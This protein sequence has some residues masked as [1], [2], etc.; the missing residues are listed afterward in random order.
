MWLWPRIFVGPEVDVYHADEGRDAMRSDLVAQIN[1]DDLLHNYHALKAS[2]RPGVKLCAP[3]KADAYG[4]S[5]AIVA[6]VLY[7]AGVDMAAVATLF[8]AVELRELGWDRRFW[9][10][11]MCSAW[12]TRR[13][14]ASVS[15]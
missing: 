13:S 10:W 4:H 12:R 9:Y 2:C 8:E 6:P 1:T 7:E 3:L 11:E 5:M 14:G 15:P